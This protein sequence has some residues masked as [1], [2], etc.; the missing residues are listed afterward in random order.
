VRHIGGR[1]LVFRT[2]LFS[3]ASFSSMDERR[4][5]LFVKPFYLKMMGYNAVHYGR[6][7]LPGI[8]EAGREVTAADAIALLSGQWRF[9]VMGA[10]FALLFDDEQVTRSVL[11]ALS[12]SEGKLNSLSLATAATVVAGASAIPSLRQYALRDLE[13]N[14][15][16]C[17]FA[18]CA[19]EHLGGT[20]S[21]CD[22]DDDDRRALAT[23]L[24]IAEQLR[25][26][27]V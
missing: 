19:I 15:G 18:A 22:P 12:S 27:R 21:S 25:D 10:W 4:L 20:V 6:D 9:S 5:S 2:T 11:Q 24:A 14:W 13:H 26:G 8:I 7:L 16:A 3:G 17:G 23:L 1:A